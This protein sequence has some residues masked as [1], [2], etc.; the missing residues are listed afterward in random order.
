MQQ[1]SRIIFSGELSSPEELEYMIKRY[2]KIA[3]IVMVC[4][5]SITYRGRASSR[6]GSAWR[7]V[8]IKEDGTVLV[9]ESK[10]RE[11]INWQPQSHIVLS[12]GEGGTLVVTA[13]RSRPHEELKIFMELPVHIT[14]ARLTTARFILEGCERDIVDY[15]SANPSLIEEGAQLVS[16]EV[17]TPYGRIDLVLRSRHGYLIVVEVK[18]SVADVDAVFQL[19]RY[20]D[21]YKSLGIEVK[22]VLASPKLTAQASKLM[23]LY[24]LI[25]KSVEPLRKS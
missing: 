7:L 10:G 4:R 3:T 23:N 5:C 25:H 13:I 16:R 19:K 1:V 20:V 12:R 11:P 14:I 9:H 6:A 8:I 18:R 17:S 22:G 15:L 2:F 24:G 21:Y